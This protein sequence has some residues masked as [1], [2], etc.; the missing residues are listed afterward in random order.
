MTP[1]KGFGERMKLALTLADMTPAQLASRI[2]VTPQAVGRW[3]RDEVDDIMSHHLFNAAK[4]MEVDAEWLS[5]GSGEPRPNNGTLSF[6]GRLLAEKIGTKSEA[7]QR[8]L[9][10]LLDHLD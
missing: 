4:A 10:D 2:E 7:T 1:M 6:T 5:T 8:L 9:N 3:L